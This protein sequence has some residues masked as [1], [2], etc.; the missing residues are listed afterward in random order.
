MRRQNPPTTR[1]TGS[2]EGCMKAP[3]TRR[4]TKVCQLLGGGRPISEWRLSPHCHSREKICAGRARQKS[5]HCANLYDTDQYHTKHFTN[6]PKINKDTGSWLCR[7]SSAG[8]SGRLWSCGHDGDKFSCLEDAAIAARAE[9]ARERCTKDA[10]CH[11]ADELHEQGD[12]CLGTRSAIDVE[13]IEWK[14]QQSGT[15]SLRRQL[16]LIPSL[17]ARDNNIRAPFRH[18]CL[19]PGL[20]APFVLLSKGASNPVC[21]VF[22]SRSVASAIWAT[23]LQSREIW[24]R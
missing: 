8:T 16:C 21:R 5:D 3:R 20:G 6:R 12:V 18:V 13:G 22:S 14:G 19:S 10:Q 7:S 9:H 1:A 24:P 2:L 4:E 15:K 23:N 11:H 17:D